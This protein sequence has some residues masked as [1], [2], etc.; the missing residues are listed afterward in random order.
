MIGRDL[1]LDRWPFHARGSGPT[2]DGTAT[3]APVLNG[4]NMGK[5]QLTL[6][7]FLELH[8]EICPKSVW[9]SLFSLIFYF[10]FFQQIAS[11]TVF[12]TV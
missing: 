10:I 8:F 2:F 6:S 7:S 12:G 5:Q 3:A 11:K 9:T 4:E 1:V